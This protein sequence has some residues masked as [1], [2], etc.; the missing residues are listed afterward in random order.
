MPDRSATVS[1]A[2]ES[3][4]LAMKFRK[5]RRKVSSSSNAI[6]RM[7]AMTIP[8]M[9]EDDPSV[10]STWLTDSEVAMHEL[11]EDFRDRFGNVSPT[12][13]VGNRQHDRP[14][15]DW[16]SIRVVE[17]GSAPPSL[18]SGWRVQAVLVLGGEDRR[19]GPRAR[20]SRLPSH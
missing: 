1:W 15:R 5:S 4:G 11:T 17:K 16:P 19:I 3:S 10:G 8:G 12:V 7:V 13:L 14:A 6:C 9:L 20:H 18:K 2:E